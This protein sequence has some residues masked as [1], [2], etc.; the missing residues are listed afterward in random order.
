MDEMNQ[1]DIFFNRAE[2][3][4]AERVY[5][6]NCFEHVVFMLRDKDHEFSMG[7]ITVMQCLAFAIENGDLPKLPQSWLADVDFALNTKFNFNENICN[8][9]YDSNSRGSS[10]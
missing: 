4:M 9:N 5:C 3:E 2:L 7:L 6:D 8:L 1:K 10:N